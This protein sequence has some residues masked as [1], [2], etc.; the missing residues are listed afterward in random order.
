[1]PMKRR[2]IV[3]GIL[4]ML[5]GVGGL[6]LWLASPGLA[7]GVEERGG[8][9]IVEDDT[10][11]GHVVSV[12]FVARP[13][14]DADLTCLRDRRGYQRLFLDS[15]RVQGAAL[16]NLAGSEELRWVSLGGC[17]ITDD[18]LKNL[19][20]LPQLELL[21]LSQTR[22][23]DAGLAHVA[24]QKSLRHLFVMRT[25]VTDAG[26]EH[27][28]G[29]DQLE[30]LQATDTKVTEAGIRRLQELIPRLTKVTIGEAE[31]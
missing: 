26:L 30:E 2:Y 1:M 31:Q 10:P 14:G 22:V 6:A 7:S 28:K 5:L 12:V 15:T 27:L 29:L 19:P 21:N 13:I 18:G 20:V 11:E 24:K 9:V 3:A 16:A 17:P 8:K 4:V 25:T 23:T